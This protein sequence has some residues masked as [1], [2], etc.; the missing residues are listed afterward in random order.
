MDGE[1]RADSASFKL[2]TLTLV[3]Y[4]IEQETV[5]RQGDGY[6]RV[7]ASGAAQRVQPDISLNLYL[8]VVARFKDYAQGLHYLSQVIRFF[9]SNRTF[10]RQ[11]APELS[12]GIAELAV[13]LVS[14]T[15]QQQNELWGLLR[16]CYWP[17]VAYRIRSITFKDEDAF[18]S[19]EGVSDAVRRG[20][21]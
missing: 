7:T 20:L 19:A 3:L 13:D 4:R 14:L 15:V 10:D 1:Q 21:S 8:L 2:G 6:N 9:Q 17:S 11:S 12:E 16:T 5:L 18:P